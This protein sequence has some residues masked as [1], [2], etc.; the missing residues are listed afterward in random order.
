MTITQIGVHRVRHGDVNDL[1]GMLQLMGRERAAI[2]YCDPPWGDGAIKMWSTLNRK[3]TGA[4]VPPVPLAKFLTS[5]FSLA[6]HYVTDYLLVEYGVRWREIITSNGAQFGFTPRGVV[7]I[8]YK[9][10]GKVLPLDLHVF[11][12]GAAMVPQG[13]ADSVAGTMG[14]QTIQAAIKPLAGLLRAAGGTPIIFDPCCGMG[15]TAQA[16]VDYGLAFRGNEFNAMR[17][18]KT[19]KRLQP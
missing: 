10:S 1:P 17:L 13:Y 6:Q 8:R 16:A 14:Y 19:I 3:N 2:M 12:K 18:A 7:G 4:V 15:Y 11:T 5:V 9:G